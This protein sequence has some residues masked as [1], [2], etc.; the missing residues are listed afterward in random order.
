MN[1]GYVAYFLVW[2]VVEDVVKVLV[3]SLV[4]VRGSDVSLFCL[5][6]RIKIEIINSIKQQGHK[7]L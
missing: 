6:I 1:K 2:M 7:I 4:V 5:Q 3:V